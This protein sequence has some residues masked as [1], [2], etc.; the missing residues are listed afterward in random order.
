MT[1]P[2]AFLEQYDEPFGFMDFAS[3]G[4]L[5]R[6][7]RQRYHDTIDLLAAHDGKLVGPLLEQVEI[8]RKLAAELV[9]TQ[10]EFVTFPASTSSG[11]FS[12]AFGLRGGSVVVPASEFPANLYP[13]IRAGE[14]GRIEPRFVEAVDGMVSAERL[15]AAM[16]RDTAAVAVSMVDFHT[17][18]RIDLAALRE[19][20]GYAL[21]VVDAVQGLGALQIS[22]QHAD[23]VV[24][25]GTKWLR[26]GVGLAMMAVSPRAM[27]RLDPVLSGWVSVEDPFGLEVPAPHALLETAD[28][29]VTGSS[30]IVAL[31]GLR[32]S[33]EALRQAPAADLEES[34]IDNALHVEEEILAA[35][36]RLLVS[37]AD[38]SVRSG[39]VTFS[40]PDEPSAKTEVRLSQ[41]G[42]V[43]TER[44]GWLRA[45]PHAT[46]S[47]DAAAAL[48]KVLSVR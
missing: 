40:L 36:G 45:S 16:D 33:L 46:T 35:G 9:G 30:P 26:A 3:I 41:A 22:M 34:V 47:P 6:P 23:V 38:R 7:A 32:G 31:A 24:A 12:V 8:T 18:Y 19:A 20:C 27:E 44:N 2:Q 11:L 1:L 4:A 5:S 48:G 29:Y 28:R 15:I 25:G 14:Y 10:A 21:L 42:F 13:W 17:G 37:L 39:I 43:I